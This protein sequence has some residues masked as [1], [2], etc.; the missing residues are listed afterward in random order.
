[1]NNRNKKQPQL[2][3]IDD[4]SV[5]GSY[6]NVARANFY[7]TM[8]HIFAS[9]GIKGIYDEEKIMHVLDALFKI[10]SGKVT[11]LTRE[12]NDW[13][14]HLRLRNEQM[15]K[16]QQL[17]FRH[18]PMLGPI[19]ADIAS[20][21]VYKN[22]KS[23]VIN[24][25][26]LMRGVSLVECMEVVSL[27]AAC[28]S[29]CRNYY[30]HF[31]PYNSNEELVKQYKRQEKVAGWLEK[32]FVAS[33]RIDK[34]RNCITASEMEFL[35]GT[36]HYFQ[37]KKIDEEGKP[38]IKKNKNGEPIINKRTGEYIYEMTFIERDEYYFK[39][40]GTKTVPGTNNHSD[41]I[42]VLSDF[43]VIYFCSLFL[44]KTH[45]KLLVEQ[46]KL[47]A[48][49][50]SPFT[51]KENNIVRE[52]LGIYRIR[53]PKG[54][55]LDSKDSKT[56][57]AMDMIN[58][59]RKCPMQLYDVLSLEGKAFFEDKVVHE[60]EQTQDVSKR[61]RYTDRFPH[62]VMRYIDQNELF[63][64]IRFQVRLGH[65]RFN[66]YDKVSIDGKDDVRA[67]QKEINGYG[68]LQEIEENAQIICIILSGIGTFAD[69]QR[70]E[71]FHAELGKLFQVFP[72][73]LD[74]FQISLLFI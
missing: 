5:V 2:F 34:K 37:K 31:N 69:L 63:R 61:L 23:N 66:F 46:T 55:R 60:N 67:W 62:L 52:M 15:V 73:L 6:L 29:D 20:Y 57:L 70:A 19:M 8:L 58:E 42:V 48:D 24:D 71:I 51:E 11:E 59:L 30:T 17:L 41:K 44:S 16:M 21:K 50:K 38:V 4:K 12:Q 54:R 1:M 9:V 25:D 7:K 13:S 27:M 10:L 36:D 32:V 64:R 18:L 45:I 26:E 35:T 28:L 72:D 65:F 39:I 33:R 56:L 74:V 47:F 53:T 43:G 68:R 40:S 14:K 3:K 22:K 49:G